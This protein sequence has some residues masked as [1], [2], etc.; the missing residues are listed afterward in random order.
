MGLS[1]TLFERN[2]YAG[3]LREASR[4]VAADSAAFDLRSPDFAHRFDPRVTARGLRQI[5]T[6]SHYF[7]GEFVPAWEILR[8]YLKPTTTVTPGAEGFEGALL[9]E[10]EAL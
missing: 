2:E 3:V 1:F 4:A 10:L 8:R 9:R 5:M 6:L 7:R